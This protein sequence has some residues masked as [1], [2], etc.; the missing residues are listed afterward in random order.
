M[1]KTFNFN[2]GWC[3]DAPSGNFI[4]YAPRI[5]SE[6]E[7][8][9]SITPNEN[10]TVLDRR[11]I[12]SLIA[13]LRREGWIKPEYI[14]ESRSEDLKIIHRLLDIQHRMNLS[15]AHINKGEEK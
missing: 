15:H 1:N 14:P 10:D 8:L 3:V 2:G 5:V 13:E 11:I 4:Y 7:M 9:R 6:E 12:P